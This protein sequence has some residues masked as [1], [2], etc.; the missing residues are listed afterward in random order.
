LGFNEEHIEDV[1]SAAL[2]HDLGKLDGSRNLLYKAARLTQE[3]Y[4]DMPLIII[5]SVY[6]AN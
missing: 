4:S 2:L 3:E 5:V 6:R 1:R